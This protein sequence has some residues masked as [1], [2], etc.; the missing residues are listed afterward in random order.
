[1]VNK[2]WKILYIYKYAMQLE[3]YFVWTQ[4]VHLRST[5]L[6]LILMLCTINKIVIFPSIILVFKLYQTLY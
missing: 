4:S 2:A 1:M 5:Y 3:F 6:I